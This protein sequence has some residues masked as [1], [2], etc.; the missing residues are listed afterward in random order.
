MKNI[1]FIGN[2]HTYFNDMPRMVQ[3]LALLSG[4]IATVTMLSHG[5]KSL[6]WHAAMEQTAFN[7]RYGDYDFCVLQDAAHPFA[8]YEALSDGVRKI[9]ALAGENPPQFVLY[10]TWAEKA[11]SENQAEMTAAYRQ[12]AAE[13][14]LLLAPVGEQWQQF[15]AAHPETEL[16][17]TDGAHASPA[18]S[19]LAACTIYTA[20]FDKKLPLTNPSESMVLSRMDAET[21]DKVIRFCREDVIKK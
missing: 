14:D 21:R 2:S 18:G 8:G 19:L 16:Y 17:F 1:L 11:K 7:L 3:E 20:I 9:R 10:M 5:G 13:Q 6:D 15:R 4:Q 12:T